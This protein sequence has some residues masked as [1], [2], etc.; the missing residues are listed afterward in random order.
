MGQDGA[1][2]R[3]RTADLS[4]IDRRD[5]IGGSADEIAV[6]PDGATAALTFGNAAELL[7][8]DG[9]TPAGKLGGHPADVQRVAYSPDGRMLATATDAIEDFIRLWDTT[10]GRL[11]AEVRANSNQRG[12]LAFS[13]DS[14]TLVAGAG[15]WTVTLWHLDPA[16]S[17]RRL[18]AMLAPSAAT[19]QN[20]LPGVCR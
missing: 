19:E 17:V 5:L 4:L 10:T 8:V 3:Y 1:V 20:P 14:S 2:W 9:L 15:D 18:C 6:S 7:R 16:D 12:Q 13:P 11:I